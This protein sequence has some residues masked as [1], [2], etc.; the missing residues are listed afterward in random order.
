MS[1][2]SEKHRGNLN[3]NG[4]NKGKNCEVNL[5]VI[6]VIFSVLRMLNCRGTSMT[7]MLDYLGF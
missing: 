6:L 5:S 3:Y 4:L 7:D 2:G 1:K